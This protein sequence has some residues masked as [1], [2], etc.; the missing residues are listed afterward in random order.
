M[1]AIGMDVEEV[2]AFAK[3]ATAKARE[4]ELI[5][6]RLKGLLA[7]VDWTGPDATKFKEE[8]NTT[9]TKNLKEIADGLEKVAKSATANANQQQATS[10]G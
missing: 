5:S 10:R 6:T 7:G 1:A 9:H 2:K 8:W 3:L 4:L